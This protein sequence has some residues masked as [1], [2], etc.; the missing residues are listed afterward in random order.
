MSFVTEEENRSADEVNAQ[1]AALSREEV[2]RIIASLEDEMAAAAKNMDFEEAARLR[3]QAVQLRARV[4]GESEV[5]VLNKMK[6][7][8][9]KGSAYGNRKHAAYGSAR[10]S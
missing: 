8:A 10:R 4:E 1:L 2:L 6:K 3:D 7:T 5:D 9:R